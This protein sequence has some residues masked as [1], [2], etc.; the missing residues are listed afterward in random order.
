MRQIGILENPADAKRFAAYLV[1]QGIPAHAEPD[2]GKWAVWV[3][4]ENQLD[5]A[6][7][8][9]I[10][11]R[12]EPGAPQYQGAERQ[13]ENRLREEQKK[14]EK[15]AKNVVKMGGRWNTGPGS[16]RAPVVFVLIAISV[17]VFVLRYFSAELA[18]EVFTH[19]VFNP[20]RSATGAIFA[21][22][23]AILH[24]QVWRLV[25]PIFLHS[26]EM[27]IIF[28]MLVLFM[29][30]NQVE[31]RMGS[32]RFALFVLGVAVASNMGQFL[33]NVSTSQSAFIGTFGGM[34]GVGYALF[35]FIFVKTHFFPSL[36]YYLS[37]FNTF[38]LF[39]FFFLFILRDVPGI[40]ETL[41][42]IPANIANAAHAVGLVLGMALAYTPMVLKPPKPS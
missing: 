36:G 23:D 42:W 21:G 12:S 11:F 9:L 24:G 7:E 17:F 10:R 41:T 19:L 25:T 39:G 29:F 18:N 4:D 13:A 34:S 30:G 32:G 6:R 40:G 33:W 15:A 14:R 26:D 22:M 3:R 38:L 2:T 8:E 28:N 37:P 27:H 31:T 35:G 5:V 20:K 1:T 16:R